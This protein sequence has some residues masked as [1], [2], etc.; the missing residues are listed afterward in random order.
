MDL[1]V[2]QIIRKQV[3]NSNVVIGKV[4]FR[5][6]HSIIYFLFSVYKKQTIYIIKKFKYYFLRSI[7]YSGIS[8]KQNYFYGLLRY[9]WS[10]DL[11]SAAVISREL[12]AVVTMVVTC[13]WNMSS[14]YELFYIS[15]KYSYYLGHSFWFH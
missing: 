2:F 13:K 7:F 1:P 3:M 11:V 10:I 4:V 15:R 8:I 6:I 5:K 14:I 9:S 12:R